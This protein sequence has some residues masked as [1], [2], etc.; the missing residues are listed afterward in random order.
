MR[1][2]LNMYSGAETTWL[3][4]RDAIPSGATILG[5][6]LGGESK[7]AQQALPIGAS[8]FYSR[9]SL[10][11]EE[12]ATESYRAYFRYVPK[13]EFSVEYLVRLNNMGEFA[14]PPVRVEA[15]YAPEFFGETPVAKL[16]VN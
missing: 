3:A 7:I 4:V 13:G 2:R 16:R 5:K 6:G 1:V 10:A 14:L 15:M 8:N 11:F 12:R 9:A